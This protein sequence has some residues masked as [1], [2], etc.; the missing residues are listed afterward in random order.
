MRAAGAGIL[1]QVSIGAE[2]VV[3][4]GNRAMLRGAKT[5]HIFCHP[6]DSTTS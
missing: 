2:R 1:C 4:A 6:D 5:T 3:T